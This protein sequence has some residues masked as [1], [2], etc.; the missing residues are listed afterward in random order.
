MGIWNFGK[1]PETKKHT[2]EPVLS[3]EGQESRHPFLLL[4]DYVA[5][6][7][8]CGDLYLSLREAV[9]IIDAAIKK[10][11]RLTGG[12]HVEC[13]GAPFQKV[14]DRF[15]EEVPSDCGSVSLQSFIDTY[16]EE[17]L[18]Y[19]TAVAELVPDEDE[20]VR[21]LYTAPQQNYLLSRSKKQFDRTQVLLNVGGEGVPLQHQENFVTT[22]LGARPG[23][24]YGTSILEGLPFVSSILLKIYEATG[25][26]W[27]R[28]G[29]VRF[30]VTYKPPEDL[31][32]KAFAKERA[33][34]IASEWSHAMR[35]SEVRDFVSVGDVQIKA[36]GA[37]TPILDSSIPVRQMLE[38]IVAKLSLP[39]FMLGLS[40]STTERMAEEQE[41]ILSTELEH[42]RR[43]LTP[44]ILYICKQHMQAFGY[45]GRLFVRWNDITLK[46]T[47]DKAKVR[48]LNAQT[49]KI[50]E[51]LSHADRKK[52]EENAK[53]L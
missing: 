32:G 33:M 45:T 25:K 38:E 46:D 8:I 21:Y 23:E 7:P 12:F 5:P 50:L 48:H 14:L 42:Y 16:F 19:G 1:N 43:V 39:P 28:V 17:L 47:L 6:A 20:A 22:A 4:S 34:Q 49:R 24:V 40:W 53:K 41:D 36:I 13:E 31:G 30:A 3:T 51:E 15:Q 44:V 11:V 9:P 27:D 10:L 18:T 37:D 2:G 26:N 35:S 52:E 29:N